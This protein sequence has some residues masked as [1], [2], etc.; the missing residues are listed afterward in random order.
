VIDVSDSNRRLMPEQRDGD[1]RKAASQNNKNRTSLPLCS[2]LGVRADQDLVLLFLGVLVVVFRVET[3]EE[4]DENDTD[5][6]A[7]GPA[8]HCA[9]TLLE[10]RE[11]PGSGQVDDEL[12]DLGGRDV[13]LPPQRMAEA[14][15][16]LEIIP[17]HRDVNA[18]VAHNQNPM[19][20]EAGAHVDPEQGHDDAVVKYMQEQKI[21]LL[22]DQDHGVQELIILRNVENV[23]PPPQTTR[24]GEGEVRVAIDAIEVVLQVVFRHF[25]HRSDQNDQRTKAQDQIVVV[26]K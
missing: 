2:L 19:S 24:L 21:L 12:D 3:A 18:G 8:A 16:G 13:L 6:L 23:A 26:V 17:V 11:R 22:Q 4:V 14:A 9:L 10:K 25:E 7:K 15:D 5:G 1:H 20:C